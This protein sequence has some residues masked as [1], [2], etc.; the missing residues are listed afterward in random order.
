[1]LGSTAVWKTP[2]CCFY[3]DVVNSADHDR[4]A[5]HRF[6]HRYSCALGF[7]WPFD[8]SSTVLLFCVVYGVLCILCRVVSCRVVSCRVVSCRVVSCRVVSCRVVSCRVVSCCVVLCCVVLCCVVLCCVV[9]CCVVLCVY[10]QIC[11]K[12]NIQTL[13]YFSSKSK[14]QNWSNSNLDKKV[15]A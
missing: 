9:L 14:K 3:C 6:L 7:C 13:T 4:T 2:L 11:T 15:L 1:M 10:F 8:S 12:N 5:M